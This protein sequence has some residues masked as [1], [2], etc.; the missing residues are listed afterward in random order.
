[1]NGVCK[2]K[3]LKLG[4]SFPV[5]IADVRQLRK[6]ETGENSQIGKEEVSADG[7]ERRTAQCVETNSVYG[8]EVA[9]DGL[10]AVKCNRSSGASSKGNGA[11]EGRARREG[12]SITAVLDGESRTGAANS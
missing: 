3:T 2:A 11:S 1:M 8:I 6:V 4:Q 12:R 9:S 10:D 7:G 5:E